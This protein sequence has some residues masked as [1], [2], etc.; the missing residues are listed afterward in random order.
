M[1]VTK[2]A[3]QPSVDFSTIPTVVLNSL[4]GED[5]PAADGRTFAKVDPATGQEICRVARSAAADISRAVDVAKRAQPAWAA[6][7]VVKRGDILRQIAL[8]MR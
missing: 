4:G 3:R 1:I 6:L 8:L 5:A 2:D 7:T